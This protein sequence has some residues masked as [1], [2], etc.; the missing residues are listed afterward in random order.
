MN[1]THAIDLR[2]Q[3]EHAWLDASLHTFA[4][5]RGLILLPALTPADDAVPDLRP[6]LQARGFDTLRV[7]LLDARQVAHA[8]DLRYDIALL[9][10]RLRAVL[11]WARHQPDLERHGVGV[12]A[13][14]T[15]AA[16][17]I[18]VLAR[19]PERASALVAYD[20]RPELAGAVPLRT[21][22]SPTLF[23]LPADAPARLDASRPARALLATRHAWH[24]TLAADIGAGP[25][26]AAATDE[27]CAWFA[28]HLGAPP[29]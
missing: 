1:A 17:A 22:A 9:D 4:A 24:E 8:A 29:P 26:N 12:L 11:E 28:T 18:R 13:G 7:S 10:L 19:E 20:G 2:I 16:A 3:A 25:A 5:S 23:L 14:D 27:A 6:A 21:L 15:P